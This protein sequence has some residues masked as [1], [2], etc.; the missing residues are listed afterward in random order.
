MTE[1]A[2]LESA[3]PVPMLK[4]LRGKA[5]HRKL[6][7]FAV[8]CC[9]LIWHLLVDRRSRSA[10]EQAELLAERETSPSVWEQLGRDAGRAE[11]ALHRAADLQRAWAASAVNVMVDYYGSREDLLVLAGNT[12]FR[13]AAAVGEVNGPAF[14]VECCT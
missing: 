3:D 9:R 14:R 13:T 5:S 10:L 12:S 1:A 11:F 8:A 2:W 4:L 6:R 7:L